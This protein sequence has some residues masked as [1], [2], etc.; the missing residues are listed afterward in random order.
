[1][2]HREAFAT[3][4]GLMMATTTRGWTTSCSA[5]ELRDSALTDAQLVPKQQQPT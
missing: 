2:V 5:V 3:V 4:I 1:M